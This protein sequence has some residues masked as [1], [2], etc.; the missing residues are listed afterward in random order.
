MKRPVSIRD[1]FAS[2]RKRKQIFKHLAS[3][4]RRAFYLRRASCGEILPPL[5]LLAKFYLLSA[6]FSIVPTSATAS[7]GVK[8][9]RRAQS[10][11]YRAV[12]FV[13]NFTTVRARFNRCSFIA[14]RLL[15]IKLVATLTLGFYLVSAAEPQILKFNSHCFAPKSRQILLAA[16]R[17]SDLLSKAPSARAKLSR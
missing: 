13:V 14:K 3:C 12:R 17:N 1:K 7:F 15:E 9:H 16:L 2:K 10:V 5:Y 4:E 6:F 8:F 11:F